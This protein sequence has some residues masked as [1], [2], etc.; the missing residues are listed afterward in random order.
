[1]RKACPRSAVDTHTPSP[2]IKARSSLAENWEKSS[3]HIDRTLLAETPLSWDTR[4]WTTHSITS[5]LH[6]QGARASSPTSPI[7]HSRSL[8]VN[9]RAR[10]RRE[11]A[12]KRSDRRTDNS[13]NGRR[14]QKQNSSTARFRH[15][16]ARLKSPGN[17]PALTSASAKRT[18]LASA[19][20]STTND[21]SHL[22]SRAFSSTITECPNVM[23]LW[24]CPTRATATQ[25][26]TSRPGPVETRDFCSERRASRTRA[27]VTVRSSRTVTRV[28]R[29]GAAPAMVPRCSRSFDSST[30]PG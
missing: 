9:M 23:G 2:L 27:I 19:S 24:M 10:R 5:V 18:G 17:P 15:R 3:S 12:S 28:R 16:R 6:C 30:V 11:K 21:R 7:Q 22:S 25:P 14:R 1:M 20:S 8:L 26:C 13:S 29:A 4:A